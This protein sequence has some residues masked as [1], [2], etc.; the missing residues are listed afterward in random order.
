MSTSA[1]PQ[2]SSTAPPIV[3]NSI[4][5]VTYKF[6]TSEPPISTTTGYTLSATTNG[7]MLALDTTGKTTV[8]TFGT[9]K[10]PVDV[11]GKRRFT[12]SLEPYETSCVVNGTNIPENSYTWLKNP[13]SFIGFTGSRVYIDMANEGHYCI[14]NEAIFCF[15]GIKLNAP[16]QLS[17]KQDQLGNTLRCFTCP[18]NL[19]TI[20]HNGYVE[21]PGNMFKQDLTDANTYLIDPNAKIREMIYLECSEGSN[22]VSYTDVQMPTLSIPSIPLPDSFT[23]VADLLAT[24]RCVATQ[25]P[26]INKSQSSVDVLVTRYNQQSVTVTVPLIWLTSE[27]QAVYQLYLEAKHPN[28]NTSIDF[29]ETPTLA[30]VNGNT[31]GPISFTE[32]F[33]T[34][35]CTFTDGTTGDINVYREVLPVKLL[36]VDEIRY[37]VGQMLGPFASNGVYMINDIV[38]TESVKT[39][40]YSA[41]FDGDNLSITPQVGMTSISTYDGSSIWETK[42]TKVSVKFDPT[43]TYMLFTDKRTEVDLHD[44]GLYDSTDKLIYYSG[45]KADCKAY[46][47]GIYKVKPT[48]GIA[49]GTVIDTVT[50]NAVNQFGNN[51]SFTVTFVYQEFSRTSFVL[52]DVDGFDVPY[53]RRNSFSGSF[54]TAISNAFWTYGPFLGKPGVSICAFQNE[55]SDN[56]SSHKTYPVI[57]FNEPNIGTIVQSSNTLPI[58]A[59][60]LSVDTTIQ[61]NPGDDYVRLNPCGSVEYSGGA[62]LVPLK[63]SVSF[64]RLGGTIYLCR[65]PMV[66]RGVSFSG[67]SSP[68]SIEPSPIPSSTQAAIVNA[69]SFSGASITQGEAI[70]ALSRTIITPTSAPAASP[71]ATIMSLAPAPSRSADT[72]T[73]FRGVPP[74]QVFPR[75]SSFAATVADLANRPS[76]A[77]SL[78]AEVVSDVP[79]VRA[80]GQDTVATAASSAAATVSRAGQFVRRIQSSTTYDAQSVTQQLASS[81]LTPP[82]QVDRTINRV[83]TSGASVATTT[84]GSVF[85]ILPS[86]QQLVATAESI[87]PQVQQVV[88]AS[89]I[90]P[91][92]AKIVTKGGVVAP[93]SRIRHLRA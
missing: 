60:L 67:N 40:L 64:F 51:F 92:P 66:A 23:G 5:G 74:S 34:L 93:S 49:S 80:Q 82:P 79:L 54:N 85:R 1:S 86:T 2:A 9:A 18:S 56:G 61:G 20:Q 88:R 31:A 8:T 45:T 39:P 70:S 27:Q 76:A 22:D 71:F 75:V 83:V 36:T 48:E 55:A 57:L 77:A 43:Y 4:A 47:K 53:F 25:M 81:S 62:Y 29:S 24:F 42:V 7:Y 33:T 90:V 38:Y 6:Y 87:V 58:Q 41:I 50:I 11:F 15:Q 69:T 14:N 3:V 78:G 44:F 10:K 12:Y 68:T 17:T 72:S 32:W 26:N 37:D 35:P 52:P 89:P 46:P 73:L 63:S 84:S 21:N 19:K 28:Q 16:I 13:D 91:R 65:P 30:T 59:T